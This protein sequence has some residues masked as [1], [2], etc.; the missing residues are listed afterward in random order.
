[1]LLPGQPAV[2][3]NR[4]EGEHLA[5]LLLRGQRQRAEGQDRPDDAVPED[6]QHVRGV[7]EGT[8][9]DHANER[10]G[11]N[12]VRQH[13]PRLAVLERQRAATNGD[14][15]EDGAEAGRED[16]QELPLVGAVNDRN[17]HTDRRAQHA[18]HEQIPAP[19]AA[20]VAHHAVAVP[21]ARAVERSGHEKPPEGRTVRSHRIDAARIF[22]RWLLAPKPLLRIR[23]KLYH[24][25]LIYSTSLLSVI[26][27]IAAMKD[28]T[29]SELTKA[30]KASFAKYDKQGTD[31]WTWEVAAKDLAYQIGS[32]NKV[33]LQ[34]AGY[35]WADGKDKETLEADFRNELA[36]ILA[37]VLYIASERNVD[38]NVAMDE[39]VADYQR[40]V[41][42]RTE[43]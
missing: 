10:G 30:V 6:V 40:K 21:A 28:Y 5:G 22:C 9:P 8:G 34:L 38:M 2:R 36:D 1:V 20:H 33:M 3:Q 12:V 7:G 39:M 27:Y 43:Q 17:D 19:V 16:R 11:G 25:Y 26:C 29:I 42:K 23:G 24:Q 35:R 31:H 32:L 41:S 14:G 18:E 15:A 13:E 37:E 4:G